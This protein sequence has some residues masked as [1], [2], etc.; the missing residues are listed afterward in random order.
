MDRGRKQ[1]HQVFL[2]LSF[3]G[4]MSK[5]KCN[6]RKRAKWDRTFSVLAAVN[7][8]HVQYQHHVAPRLCVCVRLNLFFYTSCIEAVSSLFQQRRCLGLVRACACVCGWTCVCLLFQK[9]PNLAAWYSSCVGL[10][11]PA[12]SNKNTHARTRT[13]WA[14]REPLLMK[15]ASQFRL[16]GQRWGVK[17]WGSPKTRPI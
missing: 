17:P 3:L 10:I 1:G 15:P 5:K 13:R 9:V 16:K 11:P 14:Q 6:T 4:W 12:P 7:L 8:M 2:D